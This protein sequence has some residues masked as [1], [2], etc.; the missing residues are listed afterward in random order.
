VGL[1]FLPGPAGLIAS[2]A[3]KLTV[4][5]DQPWWEDPQGYAH[6]LLGVLK[7]PFTQAW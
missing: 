2:F 4:A 5:D 7:R 1:S 3:D 6:G